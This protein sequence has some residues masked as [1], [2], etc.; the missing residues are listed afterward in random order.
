[1]RQSESFGA[2]EP[3]P[4]FHQNQQSHR[5]FEVSGAMNRLRSSMVG[6]SSVFDTMNQNTGHNGR[7]NNEKSSVNKSAGAYLKRALSQIPAIA[8]IAMFHLMIG[9]P[10]GVSYFPLDWSSGVDDKDTEEDSQGLGGPFPLP[11]KEALGIR[12][13]LFSTIIGQLVFTA[14]SQFD[15]P[16]GLQMVEN[17]E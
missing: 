12:M 17:G 16:I 4:L 9:I 14:M 6:G 2:L 1:M 11:G 8:L 13:F 15:N 10:F 7:E 3:N 5:R